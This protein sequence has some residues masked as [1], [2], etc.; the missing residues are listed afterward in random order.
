[1]QT[2]TSAD[3]IAPLWAAAR[4]MFARLAAAIGGAAAIAARDA[5]SAGEIRVIRAWL[6]P[7]EAMVRKIVLIEAMALARAGAAARAGN[8][9]PQAHADPAPQRAPALTLVVLP[10]P[11]IRFVK[12]QPTAAA[13]RRARVASLRLWP[14][15]RRSAGP[16]VRDLGAAVIVADI[17][18]ERARLALARQLAQ[19]RACPPAPAQQR[20]AGR[21]EALARV[22]AKPL[23]AI[24]RLA[25]KLAA[26][27]RLALQLACKPPPRSRLYDNP[28]IGDA[29]RIVYVGAC[30]F[31]D[32]S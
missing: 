21:I 30:T 29:S 8:R 2:Q 15:Q 14:R 3:S 23:A 17:N 27:P 7:L 24:R 18:R 5:L 11:P 22:I 31:L 20:L 26:L 25:R 16:R 28:E 4:S 9:A 1:M 13:P 10:T 19:V 12:P 32:S 6:R